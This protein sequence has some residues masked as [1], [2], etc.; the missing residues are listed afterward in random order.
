VLFRSPAIEGSAILSDY[1]FERSQAEAMIKA[2]RD[3]FASY[4]DRDGGIPAE[5]VDAIIAGDGAMIGDVPMV[6]GTILVSN[7]VLYVA[8]SGKQASAWFT[9]S[10]GPEQS[11]ADIDRIIPCDEVHY[12]GGA[13]YPAAADRAAKI[14]D[15]ALGGI[16]P[17]ESQR[18]NLFATLSPM[19]ASRRKSAD[20]VEI[21]RRRLP[22]PYFPFVISEQSA[23]TDPVLLAISRQQQAVVKTMAG[24]DY[25]GADVQLLPADRRVTPLVSLREWCAARGERV[26]IQG[27]NQVFSPFINRFGIVFHAFLPVGDWRDQFD[28]EVQGDTPEAIVGAAREWLVR[29]A[30]QLDIGRLSLDEV[31]P[32]EV[33]EIVSAK[34]RKLRDAYLPQVPAAAGATPAPA[35][36]AINPG[37]LQDTDMVGIRGDTKPVKEFIKAVANEMG[38]YKWAKNAEQWNVQFRAWKAIIERRPDLAKTLEMTQYRPR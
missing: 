24:R 11:T 2:G 22:A 36:D 31:M 32:G 10:R 25:V 5:V 23:G 29:N 12:P 17:Q 26:T 16:P 13:S 34:R 27:A 7:G 6:R 28:R 19:I 21:D 35:P 9:Y 4:S 20:L 15:D 1:E 30:P 14:E 18:P 33:A 38:G 3:Q 37:T 8:K